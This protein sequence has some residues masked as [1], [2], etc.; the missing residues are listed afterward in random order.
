L[1]IVS[2][3]L[4]QRDGSKKLNIIPWMAVKVFV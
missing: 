1:T 3:L 2:T 4:T